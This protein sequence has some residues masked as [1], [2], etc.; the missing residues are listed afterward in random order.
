[1]SL[2]L[3]KKKA[4][5]VVLAAFPPMSLTPKRNAQEVS[6][7]R[8]SL[9]F[10]VIAASC[11]SMVAPASP[12]NSTNCGCGKGLEGAMANSLLN[13]SKP[14]PGVA[15]LK[16]SLLYMAQATGDQTIELVLV[17]PIRAR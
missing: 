14:T 3:K 17:P 13:P 4:N 5:D 8:D 1:M 15:K 7:L 12:I 9:R 6:N 16:G 10:A 11:S 2:L